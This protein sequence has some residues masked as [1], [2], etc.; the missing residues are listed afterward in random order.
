VEAGQFRLHVRAPGGTRVED[1]PRLVDGLTFR[2]V[3]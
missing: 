1:P 2:S 3:F